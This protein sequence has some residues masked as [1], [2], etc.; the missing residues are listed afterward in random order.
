MEDLRINFKPYFEECY[1]GAYC[2]GGN[3]GLKV[4]LGKKPNFIHRYFMKVLLGWVWVDVIKK[5]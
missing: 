1:E 3:I 4:N 2:L 5:Q